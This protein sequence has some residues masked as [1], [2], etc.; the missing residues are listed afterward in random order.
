[1]CDKPRHKPAASFGTASPAAVPIHTLILC[2]AIILILSMGVR[3]AFGLFMQP[4]GTEFGWGR[5]VF[6]FAMG[7]QNLAWGLAQPF[8]GALGDRYGAHRVVITG[9]CLYVSGL[10]CMAFST[11]PAALALTGGLLVG[12]AHS[13]TTYSIV[14]GAMGR[15]ICPSQRSNAMGLISAAGSFGQFFMMP[16]AE[17]LISGMGWSATLLV[18]AGLVL[19]IAPLSR[20]LFEPPIR[21]SLIGSRQTISQAILEALRQRSF[22]LLTMGYFV[23]GFQVVFIGVHLPSYLKDVGL[24]AH[25]GSASLAL[26]GLFNIFGSYGAGVLGNR[27]PL[28]YLLAFI[29]TARSICIALFV[30]L[31]HSEAS[32]YLFASTMGLLWLSTVPPTNALIAR[33]FGVTYLSTL[34]GIAFM[35]H[36]VGSFLGVWFGGYLYDRFGSYDYVW[37]IILILGFYAMGLN[38]AVDEQ[39]VNRA[40]AALA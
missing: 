2:S 26:I 6:A 5:E 29:Y 31:P 36:Q 24:P 14:F 38:L 22:L 27:L 8:A 19:V 3:H 15:R 25:A 37:L 21:D 39:P 1:M 18:F 32:V 7:L 34:S 40:N 9:A 4:M 33:K 10:L 16:V 23:C 17:H 12:L 13:C 28:R 20:G 11:S 35:W 30:L